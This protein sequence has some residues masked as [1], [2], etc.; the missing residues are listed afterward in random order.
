MLNNLNN[1]NYYKN[2]YDIAFDNNDQS[3]SRLNDY[4]VSLFS[5]FKRDTTKIIRLLVGYENRYHRSVGTNQLANNNIYNSFQTTHTQRLLLGIGT[6]KELPFKIKNQNFVVK[7][8]LL[9]PLTYTPNQTQFIEIESKI[10][11]L[12]STLVNQNSVYPKEYV[13]GLNLISGVQYN[14]IQKLWIGFELRNGVYFQKQ[15]GEITNTIQTFDPVSKELL[16]TVTE[17][18]EINNESVVSS[19]L[20]LSINLT[21]RF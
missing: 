18:D 13:V 15:K 9:V 2:D 3:E 12:D 14:F 8:G 10:K 11:G 5:D 17:V 21:Y 20:N 19:F 4:S 7:Y 1:T 6:G 16:D